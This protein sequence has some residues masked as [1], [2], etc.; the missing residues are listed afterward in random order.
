VSKRTRAFPLGRFLAILAL[1]IGWNDGYAAADCATTAKVSEIAPG[2]FVRPGRH[3]VVFEAPEIANVGFVIGERCVAVIDTGGSYAEGQALR[4]AVRR[5]TALPVC[6]VINTHVHPDHI[7]GNLAFKSDQTSFVG[8]RK[9]PRALALRGDIYLERAASQADARLGAEHIVVADR[10]VEETLDL[11]L[12]NRTLRITAHATAHTDQDVS[13][14]DVETGTLWLGDL[15]FMEHVPVLDGSLKGWLQV[16]D[17]L[18]VQAAR[19]VVPGHGP[20]Q[21]QWPVAGNDT[22]RYLTVLR[23][24]T[25]EWLANGGDLR[26]AQIQVGYRE[27]RHWRLFERHHQRNVTAAVNEIEWED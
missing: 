25:R 23:D 24:E 15:V 8:H 7:L 5:Q 1:G 19:R 13:V 16:L 11:D 22:V 14:L 27:T 12:G 3:A 21:A 10:S 4:C 6:Y 26:G 17:E 9:L 20:V 18:M 2:V